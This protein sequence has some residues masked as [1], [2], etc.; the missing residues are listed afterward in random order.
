MSIGNTTWQCTLKMNTTKKRKGENSMKSVNTYSGKMLVQA[1]DLVSLCEKEIARQHEIQ[2]T[3]ESRNAK[4][5]ALKNAK[6]M[7]EVLSSWELLN[8]KKQKNGKSEIISYSLQKS[9]FSSKSLRYF[10][11]LDSTFKKIARIFLFFLSILLLHKHV[12]KLI[13]N[14]IPT[15]YMSKINCISLY[16]QQKI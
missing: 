11:Q 15:N 12:N 9:S 1:E 6:E 2:D 5:I 4:S 7:K 3:A 14:N 16:N 10:G 13:L 8:R